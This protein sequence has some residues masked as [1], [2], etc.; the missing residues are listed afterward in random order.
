MSPTARAQRRY[1]G[2]FLASGPRW[3]RLPDWYTLGHSPVSPHCFL[4]DGKRAMSPS[5]AAMV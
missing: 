2:P 1:G 5:S 3:S 4:G